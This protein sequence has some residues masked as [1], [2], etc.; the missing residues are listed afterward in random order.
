MTFSIAMRCS[1]TGAFGVAGTTSSIAVG[2]RCLFVDGEVGAVITQH[3]TDPRLGPLGLRCLR[4]G[5]T[6]RETIASMI[7]STPHAG[8]RELAVVDAAGG[9]ATHQG[10]RQE[11]LFAAA[12]APGIVAVGNILRDERVPHAMVAAA[13]ATPERPL[14][15]R[16]IHALQAGLAAGG[17]IFA[18]KSAGLNVARHPG[19]SDTDLRV[20]LSDDPLGVLEKLWRAYQ[21]QEAQFVSRVLDPDAGGRATCSRDILAREGVRI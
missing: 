19:F 12:S 2:A 8:W 1:Q 20:D 17:E 7:S 10:C 4:E 6:A 11:P 13:Q 21:P 3:R 15:D 18:L 14:A 5:A 16:L 9:T